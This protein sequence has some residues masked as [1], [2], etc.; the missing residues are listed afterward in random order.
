MDGDLDC[1]ILN[2]SYK[3]PKKIDAF[4]STR[5]QKDPYGG[6]KLFRN[7]GATFTNVTDESGIFSSAIG[8]GLGVSVSDLNG[9]MRPDIYISNDFWERDYLYLNQG[10][11]VSTG[12]T[13][14]SEEL[15]QRV[16]LSSVSSMGADVADLNN[17][18]TCEVYSTNMLPADNYRLKTTT[19][20][21][22]LPPR[23]F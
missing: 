16:S 8:F 10:K 19:A 15:P 20:F 21:D 7:D 2:N 18:G 4:K 13:T 5:L 23:R 6:D 14:F 17:D 9:D 1:Y 3:D 22:P 11:S 12:K